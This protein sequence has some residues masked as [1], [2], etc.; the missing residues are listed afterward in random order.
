MQQLR[1]ALAANRDESDAQLLALC[2]WH[3]SEPV[4]A[5][6]MAKQIVRQFRETNPAPPAKPQLL[7]IGGDRPRGPR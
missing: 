3:L 4:L 1:V 7:I 2:R 5:E 6:M